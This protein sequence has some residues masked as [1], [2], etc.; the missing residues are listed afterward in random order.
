MKEVDLN[1]LHGTTYS[2]I[3]LIDELF[4]SLFHEEIAE[5]KLGFASLI[6]M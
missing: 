6:C 4:S 1:L 5:R 3:N 2:D